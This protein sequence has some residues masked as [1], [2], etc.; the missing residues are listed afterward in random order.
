MQQTDAIVTWHG[1][2]WR[3]Y[4]QPVLAQSTPRSAGPVTVR[5]AVL[6]VLADGQARSLSA[7]QEQ[8]HRGYH[9]VRDTVREL[10]AGGQVERVDLGR[11]GIRYRVVR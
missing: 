1:A 2:K 10:V 3:E 8:T 5:E 9:A 6:A 7:M 4:E 11:S